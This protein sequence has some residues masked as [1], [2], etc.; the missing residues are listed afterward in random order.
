MIYSPS[1][2]E[3]W[4]DGRRIREEVVPL[5]DYLDPWVLLA[6]WLLP[7]TTTV[8]WRCA[9][10]VE[11]G[12]WKADQPC[13]QEHEIY[14]RM[15]E[16]GK[17]FEFCKDAGAVYRQWSDNT[18]CRRNPLL[19]YAKRIEILDRAA[20]FL[21]RHHSLIAPRMDAIAHGRFEMRGESI[22]L[23]PAQ[24]VACAARAMEQ[25]PAFRLPRAACFPPAYRAA[26][27]LGGFESAERWAER[28]RA[29][30]RKSV[31]VDDGGAILQRHHP[32]VQS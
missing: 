14:L 7:N 19:S 2:L 28:M 10:I 31:S 5:P 4:K 17:R 25:H 15:L 16:A 26:F 9:A 18:V 20:D 23:T 6:R 32:D 22:A 1:R 12:G 30:R 27:R 24:S 29:I 3:H 11:V 21:A 8:L 13:C